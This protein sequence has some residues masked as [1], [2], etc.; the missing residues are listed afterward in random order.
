MISLRKICH[1]VPWYFC[2]VV[3]GIEY[4]T[5]GQVLC[6]DIAVIREST[7][8]CSQGVVWVGGN[9]RWQGGAGDVLKMKKYSKLKTESTNLLHMLASFPEYFQSRKTHQVYKTWQMLSVTYWTPKTLYG[10]HPHSCPDTCTACWCS[11]GSSWLLLL[12]EMYL[13]ALGKDPHNQ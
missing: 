9:G 2:S 11:P 10:F 1:I 7:I 12:L 4:S 8:I 6:E 3:G 13:Q 5:H